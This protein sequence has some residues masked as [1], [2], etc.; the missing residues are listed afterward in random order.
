MSIQ[1]PCHSPVARSL[2]KYGASPGSTAMRS[3]LVR[4]MR[5]NAL[6]VPD[7]WARAL[8]IR[9]AGNTV[10]AA[11]RPRRESGFMRRRLLQRLFYS[12]R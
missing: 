9:A 4:W 6:S 10:A 12:P 2:P 11:A 3:T 8:P 5:S 1:A 7:D